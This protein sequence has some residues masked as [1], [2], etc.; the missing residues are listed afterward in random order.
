MNM[1][2]DGADRWILEL[3]MVELDAGM[4]LIQLAL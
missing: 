1:N 4:I 3:N 2:F